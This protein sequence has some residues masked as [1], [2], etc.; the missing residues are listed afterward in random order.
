[1]Y[2]A[3]AILLVVAL[4]AFWALNLVSLPGN[5]L[6]VLA[7]AIY[8][9]FVS[10]DSGA[11]AISGWVVVTVLGLATLAEIVEFLASSLGATKAGGSK[12]AAILA[13]LGSVVG[14]I[15][16]AAAGSA[17]IPIPIVGTVIGALCGGGAGALM[18]AVLGET[19]KGRTSQESWQVGKAAFWGRIF[20]SLAK[21]LIGAGA[22]A[23]VAVSLCW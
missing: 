12:R 14:A 16:G 17:L 2:I 19:A 13:L 21:S 8:W 11:T 6:C 15:A 7:T 1:M 3:I 4:A 23:V 10:P 22:V 18:G 9:Y 20:G 5:W